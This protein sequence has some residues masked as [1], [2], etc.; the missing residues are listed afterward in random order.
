M[1]APHETQTPIEAYDAIIVGAGTIGSNP[2]N[3]LRRDIPGYLSS[4]E[5]PNIYRQQNYNR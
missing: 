2:L 4:S 5:L 3:L 1:T